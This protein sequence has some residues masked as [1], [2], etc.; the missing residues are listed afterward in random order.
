MG[1]SWLQLFVV[2]IVLM[3]GVACGDSGSDRTSSLG[4]SCLQDSDCGR[5]L[6]CVESRCEIDPD[7][8]DDPDGDSDN[9]SD[10]HR[11]YLTI[12]PN[13]IGLQWVPIPPGNFEM[14]C[15]PT[16]TH[17]EKREFPIHCVTVNAF[18]LNATEVT[19]EQ[20]AAFVNTEAAKDLEYPCSGYWLIDRKTAKLRE[21]DGVYSPNP[22]EERYPAKEVTWEVASAFCEWAGGRLPSEAEMEYAARAGTT[23]TYYCGEDPACLVTEECLNYSYC[24]YQPNSGYYYYMPVGQMEPNPFGLYDM[25]GNAYEWTQDCYHEDYT[26][27]PTN[28]EAWLADYFHTRMIRGL[29]RSS[30]RA[31]EM[32]DDNSCPNSGTG[33]RCARDI[34]SDVAQTLEEVKTCDDIPNREYADLIQINWI[35]IPAGTFEMGCSPGD[36]YCSDNEKP[37]HSVSVAA[38]EMTETEITKG[39]YELIVP[40]NDE[41]YSI[42]D[43]CSVFR[44]TFEEAQ[45]YCKKIKGRLP[46]EAEWEYAARAGDT[47]PN[48]CG[49]DQSC[50]ESIRWDPYAEYYVKQGEPNAFGLYDMLGNASEWVEDCWHMSYRGAPSTS[51]VWD[52][53]TCESR[54][55][56]DVPVPDGQENRRVSERRSKST[57]YG[58][59]AAGIRCVRD[60]AR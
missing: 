46:T 40:N 55:I 26:G 42:C 60:V 16:D 18:E 50:L 44:T 1:K 21:A 8:P 32:A 3:L 54:P 33:F 22:G 5:G 51:E 48:Y 24:H 38:F 28:G 12:D 4:E 31:T 13:E 27:A 10:E 49:S 53:G 17:C 2:P 41:F 57:G 56:R 34:Q 11:V 6:M 59:G 35:P 47:T 7:A 30:N 37:R 52:S 58:S 9:D 43:T 19:N 36:E 29:S 15:S 23:S 20:L 14:G 25:L 39:Q 45:Y